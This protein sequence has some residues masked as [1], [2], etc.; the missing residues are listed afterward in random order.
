MRKQKKSYERPFRRWDK[1]TIRDEG[2]IKS[3]YGLKNKKEIWKAEN[4]VRSFRSRAKRLF[5]EDTGRDELFDRL[6]RLGILSKGSDNLDDVLELKI[7]DVLERRLQT[8]VFRKG[9]AQTPRQARQLVVHKHI[10]V[11]DRVVNIPSYLVAVKEENDIS[12]AP[13]SPLKESDHPLRSGGK[14]VAKEE[15]KKEEK[16]EKKGKKAGKKKENKAKKKAE[17]KEKKKDKVKKKADKKTEKNK[18]ADKKKAEKKEKKKDKVKEKKAK[19]APKKDR[20]DKKVE[21]EVDDDGKEEEK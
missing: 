9:L 2:R 3:Q 21:E 14:E 8:L 11:G 4:V 6:K 1:A 15:E 5:T 17:K 19:E 16:A 18:K 12:Y 10:T 13:G 7:D 20:E